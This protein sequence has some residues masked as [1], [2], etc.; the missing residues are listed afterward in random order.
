MFQGFG[1]MEA[2][3]MQFGLLRM[4]AMPFVETCQLMQANRHVSGGVEATDT[5]TGVHVV[6]EEEDNEETLWMQTRVTPHDMTRRRWMDTAEFLNAGLQGMETAL[7]ARRACVLRGII[8]DYTERMPTLQWSLLNVFLTA[9]GSPPGS[10]LP[11][12]L[13][14]GLV[15]DAVAMLQGCPGTWPPMPT[16]SVVRQVDVCSQTTEAPD[17]YQDA[18]NQQHRT[19]RLKWRDVRRFR[20]PMMRGGRKHTTAAPLLLLFLIGSPRFSSCPAT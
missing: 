8:Q 15:R 14:D 17:S 2:S 13:L 11:G 1:A 4:M 18:L 5:S 9:A 7:R 19:M 12:S 3:I 16:L 20:L 10:V 6:D